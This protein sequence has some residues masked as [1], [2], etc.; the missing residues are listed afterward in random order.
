MYELEGGGVMFH[1]HVNVYYLLVIHKS[2][3]GVHVH[4]NRINFQKTDG[5]LVTEGA[6]AGYSPPAGSCP[7]V[8]LTL[9]GF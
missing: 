2:E 4:N 6:V 7:S 5:V 3:N 8:T 9:S 1:L